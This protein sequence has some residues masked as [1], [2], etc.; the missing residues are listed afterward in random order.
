MPLRVYHYHQAG[1]QSS[2]GG[3]LVYMELGSRLAAAFGWCAPAIFM[4]YHFGGLNA[5][6]PHE[7]AYISKM[8]TVWVRISLVFHTR[9]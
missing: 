7:D 1:L 3:G 9:N 8:S 4:W 5:V 6:R 2:C